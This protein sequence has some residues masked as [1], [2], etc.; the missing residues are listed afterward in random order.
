MPQYDALLIGKAFSPEQAWALARACVEH[1][2]DGI[3]VN[4]DVDNVSAELATWMHAREKKVAVWV[5]RSPAVND[6]PT[7]WA[8]M[9]DAGVDAFTSNLPPEA[10]AWFG[11]LGVRRAESPEA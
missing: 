10:H 11:E 5:W 3:D 4:A 7:V 6:N 8:A 1:N 9:A 2:L